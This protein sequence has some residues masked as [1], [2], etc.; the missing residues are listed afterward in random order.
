[1]SDAGRAKIPHR[2]WGIALLLGA[3]VLINY[4]DRISLSVAGPILREELHINALLAVTVVS[5]L[6][7]SV[8]GRL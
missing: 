1:M 8:S 7:L 4:F 5:I 6:M 3:S 2:R